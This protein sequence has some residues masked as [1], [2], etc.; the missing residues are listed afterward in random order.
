MTIPDFLC[1]LIA[2]KG[3]R[4][5]SFSFSTDTFSLIRESGTEIYA[6]GLE[7]GTS[8]NNTG[9]RASGINRIGASINADQNRIVRAWNI[10]Y[11]EYAES[12][13]PAF[14]CWEFLLRSSQDGISVNVG[15][16]VDGVFS[17][18]TGTQPELPRPLGYRNIAAS[19]QEELDAV[20]ND[21]SYFA[22]RNNLRGG[23]FD[24]MSL[25]FLQPLTTTI[26]RDPQPP[27]YVATLHC[28]IVN[29]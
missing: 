21:R 15:G 14:Y 17:N 12:Q 28:V 7:V 19:R 22:N 20:T 9:L 24:M 13:Y 2:E 10:P 4:Y 1:R 3:A 23:T 8:L 6:Y 16:I 25:D 18:L 26:P 27:V 5:A 11:S 29:C